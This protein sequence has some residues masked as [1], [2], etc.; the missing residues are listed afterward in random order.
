MVDVRSFGAKGDGVTDDTI[1]I[2]SAIAHAES[3]GARLI[4][5]PGTYKVTSTID[6]NCSGDLSAMTITADGSVVSPVV[7]FGGTGT[8]YVIRQQIVLPKVQNSNRAANTWGSGTGIEL[9][10]ADTC[11]ITVP[12]V[13]DFAI[14]YFLRVKRGIKAL[15]SL[16]F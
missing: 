1:A 3:T 9:A 6:I 11:L 10:N 5:A 16:N 12:S 2:Q 15:F 4:G 14:G 13:K 7:R 8:S